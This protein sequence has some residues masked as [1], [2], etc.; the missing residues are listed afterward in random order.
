VSISFLA[1]QFLWALLA[2]PVVLLLHF[3]RTRRRPRL[4][5]ALFLWRQ[6][7]Q[8]ADDRRRFSPTWLLLLQLLFAAL[9]AFALARPAVSLQGPPDRVIVIDASA[10]MAARD[11]DGVRLDR[12]RQVAERLLAGGGRV[13]LVRAGLDATVLAPLTSERAALRRALLDLRAGDR[14]ADLPRAL[15]LARSLAPDGEIH[16]IGDSPAPAG[17]VEFHVLGGDA[18]NYGIT[19]FETSIGQA[20]VAVSSNDPRPQELRVVLNRAGREVASTTLLIPAKGQG[21]ITF[22]VN[23]A[24]GFLEAR[25]DVSDSD[26]LALDDVAYTGLRRLVVAVD[27]DS[28]PLLRALRAIPGIELR[29]RSSGDS[30]DVRLLTGALEAVPE[31]NV[32]WFAAPAQEPVFRSV[33][34]WAQADP[35][36]RFVDLRDT[37]VGMAADAPALAGEGWETL[38]RTADLTPVIS[39][40]VTESGTIVRA[41]FHPSQTDMVLRPAFP[42]FIANVINEFRGEAV[43]PLGTPLGARQAPGTAAPGAEDGASGRRAG[44]ASGEG[45]ERALEPGIYAG[46]RGAVAAGL[47]SASETSLPAAEP[48]EPRPPA[49]AETLVSRQLAFL[50]V[51]LAAGLLLLEWLG[52]SRGG[53]GWLRGN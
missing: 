36:L 10:S 30:V 8:S 21:N 14:H 39:R 6:A 45:L 25:L 9:A 43:V 42:T 28:G 48:T 27:A 4:V 29:S 15:E 7:R 34:D 5:S 51:A 33:R 17:D 37:V 41:S 24:D 18:V 1:P 49:E 35:L 40:R 13:A 3:L 23:E 12:A 53:A 46:A 31:G 2:L 26:A 32:L 16:L 44:D 52:W 22:P 50:L 20:Y 38:A 11:S 47:L 19:A